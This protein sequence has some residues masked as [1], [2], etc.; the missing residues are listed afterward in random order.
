MVITEADANVLLRRSAA[1][2]G[3]G[4]VGHSACMTGVIGRSKYF[5]GAEDSRP[6]LQIIGRFSLKKL[7]SASR[8]VVP[9]AD[10]YAASWIR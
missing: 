6:G 7:A 1:L 9:V 5:I 2:L 4:S 10:A 8:F 3:S